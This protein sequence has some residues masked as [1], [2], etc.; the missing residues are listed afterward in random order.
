VWQRL[1]VSA[2]PV[3]TVPGFWPEMP[4]RE[5]TIIVGLLALVWLPA[6]PL[7]SWLGRAASVVAS[8]SLF[9]YLTHFVVFPH[10]MAISSPLA[11]A[12]SLAVGIAY[13]Q[14]W[15]RVE[16]G[17]RSLPAALRRVAATRH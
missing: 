6:V 8:A 12:C 9:V 1:L 2:V 14:L 11:M 16:A 15:T 13:W 7:P 3:L 17:A 5:A 4:T 10:V